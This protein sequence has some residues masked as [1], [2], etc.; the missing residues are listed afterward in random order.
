MCAV[1]GRRWGA[2]DVCGAGVRCVVFVV[3]C[4]AVFGFIRCIPLGCMWC[5]FGGVCG[6][7]VY[8]I[9]DGIVGYVWCVCVWCMGCVNVCGVCKGGVGVYLVR[10]CA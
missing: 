3:G 5:V 9:C 1:L 6:E 7:C 8:G 10:V 4:A 2:R